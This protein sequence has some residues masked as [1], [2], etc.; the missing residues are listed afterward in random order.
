MYIPSIGRNL[1]LALIL[2]R[3]GHSFIFGSRKVKLSQDSLL[4]SNGIFCGSFYILELSTLPSVSATLIINTA[5]NSKCLR[6][7]EKFYSL[8]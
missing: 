1:I 2:D 8:A 4:I 7:N 3:L 6:L 5:S